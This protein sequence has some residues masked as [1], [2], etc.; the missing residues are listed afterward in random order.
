MAAQMPKTPFNWGDD[1]NDL[2][3]NPNPP[4]DAPF[5]VTDPGSL[6]ETVSPFAPAPMTRGDA[7]NPADYARMGEAVRQF[8]ADQ[9]DPDGNT[10]LA[11]L[12]YWLDKRRNAY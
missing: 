2:Q 8:G 9:S 10:G 12:G 6:N 1:L 11:G 3:V 4:A 5:T 7:L